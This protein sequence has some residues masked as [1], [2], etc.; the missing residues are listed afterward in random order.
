MMKLKSAKSTRNGRGKNSVRRILAGLLV[1]CMLV[2]IL[3]GTSLTAG[4]V[5][6]GNEAVG[7]EEIVAPT[8]PDA[9]NPDA[10]N[11]DATNPDVTNPD[12][13]TVT[14]DVT[15]PAD[16][17]DAVTPEARNVTPRASGSIEYV[18][19]G[20]APQYTTSIVTAADAMKSATE[21]T[22]SYIK[23]LASMTATVGFYGGKFT[24]DLNGKTWDTN[25]GCTISGAT[26]Q[27]T[28]K[29]SAGGG[30]I[31]RIEYSYAGNALNVSYGGQLTLNSGTIEASTRKGVAINACSTKAV[32]DGGLITINGGTIRQVQNPGS[33][34]RTA[35]HLGAGGFVMTGGT[36]ESNSQAATLLLYGGN[37]S[38]KGGT[39]SNTVGESAVGI[40]YD[41]TLDISGGTM[42]ASGSG[43]MGYAIYG[44]NNK[45][46]IRLSGAPTISGKDA[47]IYAQKGVSLQ[48]NIDGSYYN[49]D[50][51]S[52]FYKDLDQEMGT[53]LVTGLKDVT[54]AAKFSL[55][56]PKLSG[57]TPYDDIKKT[58]FIGEIPAEAK[59]TTDNGSSW[60][61]G[62]FVDGVAAMKSGATNADNSTLQLLS[63]I[64]TLANAVTLSSKQATAY[65]LDL[66]GKTLNAA[67][68]V[69]DDFFAV[70][71]GT[72]VIKDS[73]GSGQI[74]GRE[75][76]DASPLLYVYKGALILKSGTL[77]SS[78]K[79]I[80]VEDGMTRIE[81]GGI[82][83][84]CEA[85]HGRS[86]GSIDI[87]GGT[88]QSQTKN[89]IT[90]EGQDVT[91]RLY[92]NPILT[93]GTDCSTIEADA[94]GNIYA[95]SSDGSNSYT[96]SP[97]IISCGWSNK[98]SGDKVVQEVKD[99]TA[100]GLFTVTNIQ[101]LVLKM[102]DSY[103]GDLTLADLPVP[104]ISDFVYTPPTD[105]IYNNQPKTATVTAKSAAT[106]MG[107]I[108]IR[109]YDEANKEVSPT[110]PGTYKVK[111]DVA[112]G[113]SYKAA[114]GLEMG[115]FEINYL[116]TSEVA[117]LSGT[118]GDNDWY[119]GTVSINAP[120]S[121]VGWTISD[122]GTEWKSNL[123]CDTEKK[124]I[125]TYYLKD[126]TGHITDKKTITVNV[127]RKT[128]VIEKVEA[129]PTETT[130]TI[131][132]TASDATSGI[133]KYELLVD[134]KTHTQNVEAGTY[135]FNVDTLT[136]KKQYEYT[137]KVTD[138]AGNAAA[139]TGNFTTNA[140]KP[141][142]G[143]FTYTAPTD[144]VY[145]GKGKDADVKVN[146]EITG[147]G[148]ITLTYYK[149]GV[150]TAPI[151]PGTYNVKLDVAEGT[152]YSA[153]ADLDLEQSFTIVYPTTTAAATLEATNKGDAGWYKG[154]ATLTAPADWQIS[155]DKTTW[156]A[157]K[158]EWSQEGDFPNAE[159][160]LKDDK[161][162][163]TDKKT[164]ALKLDKTSPVISEA[165]ADAI[166]T[167]TADITVTATD[168]ITDVI[169][170]GIVKYT[171][172][173]ADNA[174][175]NAKSTA[176]SH[177]FNLTDLTA[178]TE[179]IY[180]V[181]VQDAA[182][183]KT[184]KKT[185]K[186]TTEKMIINSAS[187]EITAPVKNGTPVTKATLEKD[188][189]YTAGEVSWNNKPTKF[190]GGTAYTATVILTPEKD[191][192]F[193]EATSADVTGSTLTKTLN[194]DGTLTLSAA[195]PAT[196]ARELSSI[197]VT[198]N[199][200]TDYTYGDSFDPK[201]L[202]LTRT[203]D[204]G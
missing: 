70:D 108:T 53:T 66:N 33:T 131:T 21:P 192:K 10:I 97:V 107:A 115:T 82:E 25:S 41:G 61:K 42:T 68:V 136:A 88:L 140:K 34:L 202:V 6:M 81:G 57:G 49:G 19:N 200:K 135:T 23:L 67:N 176:G 125:V 185:I 84:Y 197:S 22:T 190:L 98:A 173:A 128:P 149:A 77:T 122:N 26:T 28:I 47:K 45:A 14:D 123:T 184:L 90:K 46:T 111:I 165:K 105:L 7:A 132:V 163:I 166:K 196:E 116:T 104:V 101:P 129:T 78:Y 63:D 52:I 13:T 203:Y 127:D 167:T 183:N 11:P 144:L 75:S 102:P 110:T 177:T 109:Y 60:T 85:V 114:A 51:I 195:F 48:A 138:K 142:K 64:N 148:R 54:Q 29:D 187:P 83:S 96:G 73:T 178:N 188:A 74:K 152:E 50:T 180:F 201:G 62:S 191:Y 181:T 146:S 168:E 193:T 24:L 204:D 71:G 179:Y 93:A 189:H 150:K 121:S 72:V 16:Q 76:A 106:G 92:G 2:T 87:A 153:I 1:L 59:W 65:T 5:E 18:V 95:C 194:A 162:H 89:L 175:V 157:D 8:N 170:S 172:T 20:G 118:K 99:A 159:Y 160:Y 130:A 161:G 120:T 156:S 145:T 169:T 86:N 151:E 30:K 37:N 124:N 133:A 4:A 164:V 55:S 44:Y 155:L 117:T 119:K 139:Q 9:T 69:N 35:V 94:A 27:I 12:A 56:N 126:T 174:E 154:N 113:A 32:N 43:S 39:I 158:V 91:L 17:E 100:A 80:W 137:V 112:E 40:A 79:G 38:I 3:P 58:L 15:K 171:L 199:P 103:P 186:F 198:T 143:D 134:G 31:E 141:S 36:I 182:G 147:M